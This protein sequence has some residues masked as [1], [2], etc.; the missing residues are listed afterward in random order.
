MSVMLEDNAFQ[1]VGYVTRL[2]IAQIDLMKLTVV[3]NFDFDKFM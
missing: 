2:M 3:S 1:L